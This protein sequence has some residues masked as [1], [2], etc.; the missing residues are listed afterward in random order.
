MKHSAILICAL[1]QMSLYGGPLEDLA[2]PM[3]GRSMRAT[4]T[5]R[6]GEVRRGGKEKA[7]PPRRRRAAT[8]NE[9]SNGDNFRVP[10]TA[11]RTCCWMKKDRV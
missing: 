5:M 9:A 8:A 2:K 4:S 10:R 7:N 11:K 6:E 1:W 3:E